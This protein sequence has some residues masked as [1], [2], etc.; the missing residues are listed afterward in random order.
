MK[1]RVL[2]GAMLMATPVSAQPAAQ[3]TGADRSLPVWAEPAAQQPG[4]DQSFEREMRMQQM[5]QQLEEAVARG[6]RVVERQL[7]TVAPQLLFFAGPVQ[8]RGF[9]IDGHGI[10]FDV[11][12][13]VVRRSLLWSLGALN[14]M[15]VGMSAALRDLRSRMSLLPDGPGQAVLQA[16]AEME[17]QLYGSSQSPAG[18]SASGVRPVSDVDPRE[19][20]VTALTGELTNVVVA[21]G[22]SLGVAD[23]EWLV[24]AARDGRGRA[25]PRLAGPRR[26]LLLRVSGRDLDELRRGRLST[27]ELRQRVETP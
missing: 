27:E 10:F 19:A 9:E 24:V 22:S 21:F 14:G 8:A 23:D 26:T 3:Q 13:P 5:E 7:P 25:D 15:D 2:V 4:A 16:I 12:Y 17:A 6:V 11:E 20:Y 1:G 18:A